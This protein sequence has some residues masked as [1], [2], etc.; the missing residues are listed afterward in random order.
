MF[1]K[2]LAAYDHFHQTLVEAHYNAESKTLWNFIFRKKKEVPEAAQLVA[3]NKMFDL[4]SKILSKKYVW[5]PILAIVS[6][7]VQ[8]GLLIGLGTIGAGLVGLEYYRCTKVREDVITEVNFVGQ[9]VR[10]K[11]ADLCRLHRAQGHHECGEFLP[12][13]LARVDGRH[14]PRHPRRR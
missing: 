9:T 4:S 14:D 2:L 13:R 3:G 7:K 12:P 8:I 1:R 6:L 11:R 5:A 10:G